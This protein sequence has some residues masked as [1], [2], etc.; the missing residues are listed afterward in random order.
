MKLVQ[1]KAEHQ[2]WPPPAGLRARRSSA[3]RDAA[4]DLPLRRIR[5]RRVYLQFVSDTEEQ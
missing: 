2:S 3:A 1:A 5:N 4:G